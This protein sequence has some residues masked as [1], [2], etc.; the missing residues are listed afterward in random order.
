MNILKI[1][2]VDDHEIFLKGLSMML[3]EFNELKVVGET[4]NGQEFLQMLNH[5]MPDIVLM[6][7]KMPVLN[8]VEATKLAVEKIPDIKIIALTMFGEQKNL[9]I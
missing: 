5:I 7:I 3:N 1:L 2:L 6:D 8:G 9:K 4:N